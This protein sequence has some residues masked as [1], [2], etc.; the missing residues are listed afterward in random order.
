M[1]DTGFVTSGA[2]T[3][4]HSMP[5]EAVAKRL[6]ADV[7]TGLTEAEAAR[8]RRHYGPNAIEQRKRRGVA[9][10]IVG[11]L[12]D[13]MIVVLLVAAVIAGIVGDIED[14]VVIIVIVVLNAVIGTV[15]EYRAERALE[16]LQGMAA[17]SARI[18]R[19]GNQR[20]T[21]ATD[22]VPGDVV[23]NHC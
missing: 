5:A 19:D 10:M 4:W 6:S 11:Q 1:A 7:E 16:A 20:I 23:L 13:V 9:S 17:P 3:P 22:V 2:E 12:S 8:R 14:S 15:Q 18:L 21:A